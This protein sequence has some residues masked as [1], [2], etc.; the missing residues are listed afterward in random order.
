MVDNNPTEGQRTALVTGGA[1]RIG[2]AI[3]R[4]LHAD[5][6]NLIIHYRHSLKE[7]E[8]LERALN[9]LRPG[10]AHAL[11]GDLTD[12]PDIARMAEEAISLFGGLDLLINNASAFFPTPIPTHTNSIQKEIT[13]NEWAE[14]IETNLKAPLF[15]SQSFA[16]TLTARRGVIINLTD[17][18][19]ERPLA[20]HALYA[21]SKGGLTTLTRALARDLG[22]AVRV[23]A[24]APGAILWPQTR[25][26]SR[27]AQIDRNTPLGS[28]GGPEDIVE[29]VR[30]LAHRAT[31]VTG[32]T[33]PVDGGRSIAS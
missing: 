8:T 33:I 3:V 17:I 32:Q 29:T 4:G 26:A 12:L 14:L 9:T 6:I 5:G 19:A 18:Y 20:N 15:L 23:N 13:E 1:K 31:Y 10:S 24:I 22:P 27:E 2:A 7:A 16:P 28:R 30:F 21:L 25:D 11:Q